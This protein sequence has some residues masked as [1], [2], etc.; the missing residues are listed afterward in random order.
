M[1]VKQA[2]V[3]KSELPTH[4]RINIHSAIAPT[5]TTI[6]YIL[7]KDGGIEEGDFVTILGAAPQQYNQDNAVVDSVGTDGVTDLPYFIIN[8]PTNGD[9]Y[10]S[11]GYIF[12]DKKDEFYVRYRIVD[13]AGRTSS[14]SPLFKLTNTLITETDVIFTDGGGSQE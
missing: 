2:R 3:L 7:E 4:T 8:K 1:T 6:K 14:W 13:D 9:G 12:T 10:A 11:G 5:L